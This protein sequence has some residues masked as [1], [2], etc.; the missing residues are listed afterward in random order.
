MIVHTIQQPKP[1][2]ERIV[3]SEVLHGQARGRRLS[4]ADR[5]S[6]GVVD[7]ARCQ[8]LHGVFD[9]LLSTPLHH[10]RCQQAFCECPGLLKRIEARLV[11]DEILLCNLWLRQDRAWNVLQR[12]FDGAHSEVAP[13]TMQLLARH[14]SV[15]LLF[16]T[17][18]T[19][20]RRSV[21]KF[22]MRATSASVAS[23]SPPFVS[24]S[25]SAGSG[26]TSPSNSAI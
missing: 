11:K 15:P 23:V 5:R 16:A 4:M 6:M 19:T 1:L 7:I 18:A 24:S 26:P 8:L 22:C 25:M 21:V 2:P 12:R 10:S 13:M 20:A 14:R 17:F 3:G 9:L